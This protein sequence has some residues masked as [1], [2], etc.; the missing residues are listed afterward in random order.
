MLLSETKSQNV[1]RR[2]FLKLTQLLFPIKHL[3]CY[4]KV[5]SDTELCG[6]TCRSERVKNGY[7]YVCINGLHTDG[8]DYI[9]AAI[10]AG[11]ALIIAEK[12]TAY[13]EES[14]TDYVLVS[15]SRAALTFLC[16]R[17]WDNPEKK[18][19]ITAVTGTN[20]KTSSVCL[21]S[22]IFECAKIEHS[23]IGTLSGG[24]TTPDPE[25][26]FPLFSAAVTEGKTDIIMEASSHALAL[27]KLEG[28][29]FFG[30]I[31]SNLTPEHLDFH[32]SMHDYALTKAKLFSRCGVSLFN[33]DDKYADEVSSLCRENKYFYSLE[34]DD[35]FFRVT[36]PVLKGE[37]GISFCLISP[38]G[39]LN[40]ESPLIGRFNIYNVSSV[41]A[42]AQ[43]CGIDNRTIETAMKTFGIVRGRL[44]K[45]SSD[46]DDI[47]VF[48]DYAHT[49][50]ALEKVLR[51]LRESTDKN[52]MKSHLTVLFGCGGDRD[53]SKRRLMGS[54]AS[55]LA[56]LV[57]VTSDNRRTEN[58]SDI[59]NEILKGVDKEKPHTV[60]E[61]RK[62]AIE[63][64]ISHAE[65]RDIVLLAGKGHEEYEIIGTKKVYFSEREIAVKALA[66]RKEN[67]DS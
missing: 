21:L 3:T 66:K 40:I 62:D 19:R 36:E 26:L 37:N 52:G 12:A 22:K 20:G 65:P 49:P 33:A 39:K 57:V 67:N 15:D 44:E 46:A 64:A 47:T 32:D 14:G 61:N 30:G 45:V 34:N 29:R 16:A 8:H 6:V 58:G 27:R 56:D 24:L 48:I 1:R 38:L 54:I 59:I 2:Y 17:F 60:I 63:Y 43:L 18:L 9:E 7:V 31:F 25:E 42:F 5:N 4:S 50:D 13:L 10:K 51:T 28:I 11:A 53:R 55:R 23:V 35:V 41:C